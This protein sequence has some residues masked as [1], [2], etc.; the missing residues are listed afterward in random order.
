[1]TSQ[2]FFDEEINTAVH[3][4]SPYNQKGTRNT[5]NSTDNI[6]RSGGSQLLVGVTSDG[7]GGYTGTFDIGLAAH[8]FGAVPTVLALGGMLRVAVDP[9]PR[10]MLVSF[11]GIIGSFVA[12]NLLFRLL[13]RIQIKQIDAMAEE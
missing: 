4:Q 3:A 7:Q 10:W 6:Y 5:L 11:G 13:G 8:Q 1:M 12:I 2:L 9:R